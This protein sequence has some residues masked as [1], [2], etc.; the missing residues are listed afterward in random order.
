MCLGVPMQVIA[1]N[2]SS[3]RCR[4]GDASVDIDMSLVGEQPA[5]TWVLVFLGA[6][7]ECLSER[8]AAEMR[9]ALNA[10]SAVMQ[11]TLHAGDPRLDALFADLVD[12]EPLL[13]E[14]LRAQIATP[15]TAPSS[16]DSK[17]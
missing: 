6:A 14:H 10:V 16:G 12:R 2:E 8:Q 7:R 4:D 1:G 13:P 5:G 9:A 11:G 3:A 15:S 17:P